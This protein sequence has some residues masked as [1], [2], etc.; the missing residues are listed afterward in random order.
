MIQKVLIADSIAAVID[1]ALN[2]Y[3]TLSTTS[4]WLCML[5]YTYQLYFDFSGYSN[6]A[7]GLGYMF[8]IRIP[9]NFNSPYKA[10][11]PSDFWRRWHISLSSCLRD[12]VFIP[13]GGNRGTAAMVYR[14]L[15]MTMLIGGLWHGANWTFV[16][17]GG[18][19]GL[20]LALYRATATCWDRVPA[21]VTRVVTFLLVIV[22]WVFF[23]SIDF[24]MATV[25]LQ[26][27]FSVQPGSGISGAA[28][29]LVTLAVAAFLTHLA[30]NAFEISH[31]WRPAEALILA[32]LLGLCLV[33]IY[34]GLV[35]PFLYFQF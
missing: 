24:T 2:N 9:Q 22:G 30:P 34:G 21:P 35:S 31:Q 13:L 8:G 18:Y 16:A 27:M 15:L 17:W 29:L 12:Y 6:M 26:T 20:L 11:N 33:V 5:G 4:A 14:N 3:T 28:G 7:V 10:V 23:R 19:H 25:L 1:P 32:I